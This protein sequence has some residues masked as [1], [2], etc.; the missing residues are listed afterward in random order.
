VKLASSRTDAYHEAW[1]VDSGASFHMNP[2]R[3]W[4]CEYERYDGGDVFIG[5]ESMN[6]IIGQLK[7]KLRIMDGRIRTLPC[8]LHIPRLAR[9][10]IYVRKMEDAGIQIVF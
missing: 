7:F 9:N 3:E 10:L 6:K 1:L 2:H 5:D 4:F 8:L